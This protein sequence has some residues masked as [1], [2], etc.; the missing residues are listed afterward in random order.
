MR[1]DYKNY[2]DIMDRELTIAAGEVF[3]CEIHVH[4]SERLTYQFIDL[5]PTT[6]DWA[7]AVSFSK[8]E[9]YMPLHY[10]SYVT[11][12]TIQVRAP[13]IVSIKD[14]ALH[15]E[16]S[17]FIDGHTINVEPGTYY[18]SIENLS[19]GDKFFQTTKLFLGE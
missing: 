4:E 18:M 5:D 8:Q 10:K 17:P 9:Y 15:D 19:G 12:K 3:I 6:Q 16:V 11:K 14:N 7:I 13:L 1:F 2:E